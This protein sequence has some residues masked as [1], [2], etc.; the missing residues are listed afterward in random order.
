MLQ[1]GYLH[2][3]VMSCGDAPYAGLLRSAYAAHLE[4]RGDVP[5]KAWPGF[6]PVPA[7]GP[8]AVSTLEARKLLGLGWKSFTILKRQPLWTDLKPL[9][10]GRNGTRRSSPAA[11]S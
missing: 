8:S 5:P 1:Y 2:R 11:T 10:S 4:S 3:F 7:S 9:L 6:L